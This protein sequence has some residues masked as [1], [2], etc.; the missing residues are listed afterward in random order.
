MDDAF[1]TKRVQVGAKR[2]KWHWR[3]KGG[4]WKPLDW[5]Q[6]ICEGGP[7]HGKVLSRPKIIDATGWS[8]KHV[9]R[10]SKQHRFVWKEPARR[11]KRRKPYGT[12]GSYNKISMWDDRP[13]WPRD[14]ERGELSPD[15]LRAMN[16]FL[17]SRVGCG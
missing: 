15:A 1:E 6:Y 2:F 10:Q 8:E 9:I 11:Y 16:Q 3:E 4:D 17:T 7:L 14:G 12:R 5:D 13:V